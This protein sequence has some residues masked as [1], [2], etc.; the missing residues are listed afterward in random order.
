M[1]ECLVITLDSTGAGTFDGHKLDEKQNPRALQLSAG[2]TSQVFA[3]LGQLHNLRSI[4]LESH[5]KVANMGQK[6]LEYRLGD[7]V[8]QVT[9]NYTEN[10]EA[11]ELVQILEKVAAVEEHISALE[12]EMKYDRL[13]LSEELLQIQTD[14]RNKRLANPELLVP[15]LEKIAHDSRFLHLAQ[16]RSQEIIDSI[17]SDAW[18]GPFPIRNQQSE[19]GH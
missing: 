5:K 12:F 16:V 4:D 14:L 11:E 15:T 19:V 17:R 3:L 1:P 18:T 7:D 9:F 8:N 10:R 13:G 6:R 2:T